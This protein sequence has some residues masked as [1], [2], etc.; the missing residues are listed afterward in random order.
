MDEIFTG[1]NSF[2]GNYDNNVVN[3]NNNSRSDYNS[4]SRGGYIQ[5]RGARVGG[6]LVDDSAVDERNIKGR[7]GKLLVK[8]E[9]SYN[10]VSEI[11]PNDDLEY[12]MVK[13][14]DTRKVY[15][16]VDTGGAVSCIDVEVVN[17]WQHKFL[18][19]KKLNNVDGKTY[20]R[21]GRRY[22]NRVLQLIRFLINIDLE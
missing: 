14:E 8:P 19:G 13:L 10:E 2:R 21:C 12:V 4:N 17:M 22:R 16:L 11:N 20:E 1:S 18:E 5:Q 15:A 6:V 9:I 3:N 7:E